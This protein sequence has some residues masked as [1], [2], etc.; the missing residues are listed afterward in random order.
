MAF[1]KNWGV[2]LAIEQVQSFQELVAGAAQAVAVL[3]FLDVVFIGPPR[4]FEQHCDF[5]SVQATLLADGRAPR[6]G[7]RML[8]HIKHY[9]NSR[10]H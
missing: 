1:V 10:A 5:L 6:W 3:L 2:G 4:W 9:G 7:D 8:A